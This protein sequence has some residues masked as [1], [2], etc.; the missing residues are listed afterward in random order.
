[1]HFFVSAGSPPVRCERS[2]EARRQGGCNL[3][4]NTLEPGR[5]RTGGRPHR[6]ELT[7]WSVLVSSTPYLKHKATLLNKPHVS[8]TAPSST[9]SHK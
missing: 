3:A 4:R 7:C 8:I 1:M 9:G 2:L 6:T 5:A